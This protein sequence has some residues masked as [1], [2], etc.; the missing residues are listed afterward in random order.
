ML[1]NH[2]LV[3]KTVCHDR[4]SKMAGTALT[5]GVT[6]M[7]VRFVLNDKLRGVECLQPLIE[8]CVVGISHV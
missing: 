3:I 4:D 2:G 1:R 8:Q 5:A 6:S 7:Q